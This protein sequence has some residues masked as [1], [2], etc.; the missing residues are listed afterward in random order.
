MRKAVGE[1]AALQIFAKRLTHIGLWRVMVTLPIELANACQL[2]PG[3]DVLGY[4]WV[5]QGALRV[6]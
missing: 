6:A 3:L 4:C 5:Q 1:N 2:M